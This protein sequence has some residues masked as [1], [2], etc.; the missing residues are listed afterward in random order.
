M[1]V[2]DEIEDLDR[3]AELEYPYTNRIS[4]INSYDIDINDGDTDEYDYN[5]EA[6]TINY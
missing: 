1:V 3:F 4:Y 5:Y 6:S 2:G